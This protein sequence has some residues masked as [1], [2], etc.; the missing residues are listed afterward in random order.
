MV[1]IHKGILLIHKKE[2]HNAICGN[3]DGT[4]DSHP[5][6]SK[7]E[8]ERQ[9]SYDITHIWYLIYSTSEN[10]HRKENHGLGEQNC[11]C[12]RGGKEVEWIGTLGL[13]D[14]NYCFW[15]VFTMKSCC[16]ALRTMSRYLQ[17]SMTM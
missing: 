2:Q 10:F 14:A 4:R 3:I 5:E 16:L 9:M 17:C 1:Y 15:N 11:G 12:P 6:C 13:T 7:S 8:R